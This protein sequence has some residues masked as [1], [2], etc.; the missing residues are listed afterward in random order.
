MVRA[1]VAADSRAIAALLA[2]R[3]SDPL[4]AQVVVATRHAVADLVGA[5][6]AGATEAEQLALRT[7]MLGPE[8]SRGSCS[9]LPD[10][11]RTDVRT[12]AFLNAC[13]STAGELDDRLAEARTHPGAHVIPLA[14][15]ISEEA[16]LS[17]GEF[18]RAVALG[19]EAAALL[20]G[21]FPDRP[22]GLHPHGYWTTCAAAVAAARLLGLPI[23]RLADLI[24]TAVLF[25]PRLPFAAAWQGATIRNA[26]AGM[27]VEIAQR[28]LQCVAAGITAPSDA[29][30]FVRSQAGVSGPPRAVDLSCWAI[31]RIEY[32]F[33]PVCNSLHPAVRAMRKVKLPRPPEDI[34]AIAVDGPQALSGFMSETAPNALSRRFNL[35]YTLAEELLHGHAP[36]KGLH[37]ADAGVATLASKVE[38][39][40]ASDI[41]RIL[42]HYP[43]EAVEA[44]A[45]E[46][47]DPAP[48]GTLASRLRDKFLAV[49]SPTLGADRAAAAWT[50]LMQAEEGERF[51][52]GRLVCVD[53]PC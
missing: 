42:I 3:W 47:P 51:D 4:P 44:I 19:Y 26:Y 16:G 12:A 17:W 22:A 10:S 34:L 41:Y 48:A 32:K 53:P 36:G 14:A 28:S 25:G 1:V 9:V 8:A 37:L 23:G 2:E 38:F 21:C 29:I 20:G 45:A 43:G 40:V 18:L 13:A 46:Q 52:L 35:R 11:T 24:G 33:L 15:A 49:V 27:G 50:M 31:E 39:R 6:F 5:I 30:E 7:A